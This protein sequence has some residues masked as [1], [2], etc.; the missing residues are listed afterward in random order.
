[1]RDHLAHRYFDPTHAIVRATVDNDLDP[2][3]AAVGRLMARLMA[4]RM[5]ATE[6]S[7]PLDADEWVALAPV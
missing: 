7:H 2:L 5:K 4:Y 1:M 6:A 3:P